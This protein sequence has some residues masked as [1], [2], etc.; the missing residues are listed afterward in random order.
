[1]RAVGNP[2]PGR[3]SV[4]VPIL[5]EAEI[6]DEFHRRLTKALEPHAGAYEV[7]AVD[8]GSTDGT[9]EALR[10]IRERDPRWKIIRL[11]RNFGHGS[12]CTA[13]LDLM[14]TAAAVLIDADLQDPPE[15]IAEF[16][17]KWREGYDVVYGSRIKR[18]EGPWRQ[19]LVRCFYRTLNF[20]SDTPLPVNAGIFSLVDRR[21]ADRLKAL[22][23]RQRY[24]TGLR[25]WVGFNQVAVPY[26]RQ[27]RWG[28]S[29]SQTWL[30]LIKLAA[31]AIFSFSILPLRLATFFGVLL[32]LSS[33]A[34]GADILYEK[35][36]TDKPIIGWTSTMLA[37]IT[38]GGM[39][40]VT[41]GIIGEYL[42]RIYHEIKQRPLYIVSQSFGFE[43]SA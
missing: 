16:L 35:L 33:F 13:G 20:F 39:I 25:S 36:F 12:A 41:L 24:L 32:A 4:I 40:L 3:F 31:D 22:P 15:V 9:L 23:E 37:I 7:I 34:L 5:D 27:E 30:K 8:D 2:I 26:E 42:G 6:L 38:I 19:F 28:S 14:D 10:R 21:V 1:M 17:A 29:P 18:H 43:T 11:S